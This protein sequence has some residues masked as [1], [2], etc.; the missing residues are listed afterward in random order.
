VNAPIHATV[1]RSRPA[2]EI[3]R[4]RPAR[5]PRY[6]FAIAAVLVAAA[7]L[8]IVNDYYLGVASLALVYVVIGCAFNLLYGYL[9]MLSFAQVAFLGIGGYASAWC[10]VNTSAPIPLVFLAGGAAAAIAAALVGAVTV[11]LSEG[12]FAIITLSFTL[13]CA[14]VA[15]GRT[16]VTGGR[17]GLFG[18]PAPHVEIGSLE[19]VADT[20]RSYYVLL[21]V[22]TLAAVWVMWRIVTSRWGRVMVA[23]RDNEP[24]AR[25]QGYRTNARKLTIFVASAAITGL[26]G[27]L[28]V[29]RLTTIDPSIFDF[30]LMQAMLIIVVLGGAGTFWPVVVSAV[31]FAMLPEMLR[32]AEEWRLVVYGALLVAGL[33]VMPQGVGGY[34]AERAIRRRLRRAE[35]TS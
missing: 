30:Y 7:P 31:A 33:L 22:F 27:S 1:R 25:A 34:L 17:Q 3:P 13:L 15:A 28:H 8:V 5:S 4:S 6:P 11:R 2:R 14:V 18:L 16:D 35:A 20:E 24:L 23:I 19:L 9:G 29:F 21:A 26:A 10:A 32:S 12:A